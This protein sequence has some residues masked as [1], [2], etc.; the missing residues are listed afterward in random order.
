M[1]CLLSFP[2]FAINEYFI[3]FSIQFEFYFVFR[4]TDLSK[5]FFFKKNYTFISLR[6]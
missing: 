6:V 5:C 1:I 2:N 4:T 3:Y